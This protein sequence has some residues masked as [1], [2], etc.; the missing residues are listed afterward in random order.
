MLIKGNILVFVH[1]K[2]K[3]VIQEYSTNRA[4]GE[5]SNRL[6]GPVHWLGKKV[7]TQTL[8]SAGQISPSLGRTS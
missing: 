5:Y 3:Y 7:S 8:K 2:Q 6:Q 4:P 1:S